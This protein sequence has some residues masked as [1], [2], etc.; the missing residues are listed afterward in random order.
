MQTII[1]VNCPYCSHRNSVE[2]EVR[3][4]KQSEL[5][6]CDYENGGCD[7]EFAI[8]HKALIEVW[9]QELSGEGPQK[10]KTIGE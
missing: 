8:F 9:T 2:I 7:A 6:C 3:S 1:K 5:V 4:F 10:Q